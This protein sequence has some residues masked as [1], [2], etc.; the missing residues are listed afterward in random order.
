MS[1]V[2]DRNFISSRQGELTVEVPPEFQED[3]EDYVSSGDHGSSTHRDKIGRSSDLSRSGSDESSSFNNSD[4]EYL[5]EFDNT[6]QNHGLDAQAL[7]P[8]YTPGY[9]GISLRDVELNEE[10]DE[11]PKDPED[12]DMDV[13][14]EEEEEAGGGRGGRGGNKPAKR[15][16]KGR[17]KKM[18]AKPVG[19]VRYQEGNELEWFDPNHSVWSKQPIHCS[20]L[21]CL[22]WPGPAVYHQDI[23]EQLIKDAARLGR[24]RMLE[25]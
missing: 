21:L 8:R 1:A 6:Y 9:A 10:Y 5:P 25:L 20:T 12:A 4:G 14:E 11:F 16:G 13:D 24:Y 15:R 22:T 17:G 2:R 3:F 23:R 19:M 7:D 18:T